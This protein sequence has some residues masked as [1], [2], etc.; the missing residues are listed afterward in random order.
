[1]IYDLRR[2][3]EPKVARRSKLL[4]AAH[5][6]R[7]I[8][9]FLQSDFHVN[10]AMGNPD[11]PILPPKFELE[12]AASRLE[13]V[14]RSDKPERR[15]DPSVAF[16]TA[17]LAL[18]RDDKCQTADSF[19][20]STIAKIFNVSP[21]PTQAEQEEHPLA[22][23]LVKNKPPIVLDAI[24]T[25]PSILGTV[26]GSAGPVVLHNLAVIAYYLDVM[27]AAEKIC[28][29]LYKHI[30]PM[31]DWLAVRV[32]FLTMDVALDV[33]NLDWAFKVLDYAARAIPHI[34]G[35][36]EPE[37]EKVTEKDEGIDNIND[38]YVAV[39]PMWDGR[40]LSTLG[41]VTSISS[42]RRALRIYKQRIATATSGTEEIEVK[43]KNILVKENALSTSEQNPLDVLMKVRDEKNAAKALSTLQRVNSQ[44]LESTKKA[45]RPI[46]LNTLGILHS[47]LRCHALGAVYLEQ[48]RQ[49]VTDTFAISNAPFSV[50]KA[51]AEKDTKMAYNLALQYLFLKKFKDALALFSL[52]AKKSIYL[53]RTSPYLWIRIA[54]CCVGESAAPQRK[55][56]YRSIGK[57]RGKRLVVNSTR[58]PATD[59]LQYAALCAR[60]AIHLIDTQAKPKR[61]DAAG[62]EV[63]LSPKM[64]KL[65]SVALCLLAYSLLHSDAEET[66]VVCDELSSTED[67]ERSTLGRL[68]AAEALCILGKSKEAID[69]L[70]PLLAI[71]E[72][73]KGPREAAFTS[74]ALASIMEDDL[75]AAVRAAEVAVKATKSFAIDASPRR[76]ALL[77]AAYISLRE[78][79][80]EGGKLF[81]RMRRD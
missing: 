9:P 50:K 69:R 70:A 27:E 30:E 55:S 24:A 54:E 75:P 81:L 66:I 51:M 41:P 12:T 48:A 58:E 32:C 46:V 61:G 77:A 14:K 72:E 74:T 71:R 26:A 33:G 10:C 25:D 11:M 13:L 64:K 21:K 22:D 37:D 49:A 73:G 19:I 1:M 7:I 60:S 65:R 67:E 52:V 56:L 59:V 23:I 28:T 43:L 47:R 5:C 35:D 53:A 57:G 42:A 34:A 15:N 39:T 4:S 80:P 62:K 6:S 68:Y 31:D 79:D 3:Q 36:K 17:V 20:V 16:N 18:Y 40:N 45:T 44:F 38:A 76:R 63:P 78:G 8:P 29:F 2:V